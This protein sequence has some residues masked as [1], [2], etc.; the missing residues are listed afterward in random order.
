MPEALLAGKKL[1]QLLSST[2][3]SNV[4]KDAKQLYI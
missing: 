1:L 4:K 3:Y 2:I